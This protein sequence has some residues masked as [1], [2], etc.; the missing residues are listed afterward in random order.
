MI[1]T[2]NI[3]LIT[4]LSKIT[5]D[6]KYKT[7][8]QDQQYDITKEYY[9][10]VAD[11]DDLCSDWIERL[12][13]KGKE[14]CCAISPCHDHDIDKN[15]N[16]I[17]PHFHFIVGYIKPKNQNLEWAKGLGKLILK[18]QSPFD[19]NHA[20]YVRNIY[21]M[22]RYL[23]HSDTPYKVRY[24]ADDV[25]CLN[26]FNIQTIAVKDIVNFIN[27]NNILDY[28]QLVDQLISNDKRDLLEYT[29]KN[30]KLY[31]TYLQAK[32]QKLIDSRITNSTPQKAETKRFKFWF[33]K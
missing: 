21:C 16:K 14:L 12:K 26:C 30:P 3:T 8:E 4:Q 31:E 32:R 18:S 10:F 20:D 17:R 9:Q 2:K 6:T 15:G 13:K 33:L 25:I 29:Y 23:T 7:I 5:M 1:T 22:Y 24:N 19:E 11:V 27:S 28:Q